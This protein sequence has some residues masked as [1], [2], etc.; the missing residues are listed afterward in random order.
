MINDGDDEKYYY[1]AVKSTLELY[2]SECLKS[3]KEWITNG[4]KC[5][6]NALNDSL[7]Y[8]KMKNP[9]ENIKT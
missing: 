7:D 9:A 4:D 8:Q 3:K 5:F 6:Q 1:L 2:S